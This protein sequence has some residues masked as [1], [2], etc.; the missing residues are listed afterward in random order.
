[1]KTVVVASGKGGTG[2]TTLSVLFAHL[3]ATHH[4]LVVA[5]CDVEASNL[6]L[7]LQV[8]VDGKREFLGTSKPV[9]DAELCTS[10]AVC[11]ESCRF[12]AISL[13]AGDTP[14][15]DEW[16]CEGC[17]VCVSDCP[18]GAIRL[19]PRIAGELMTGISPTG[20]VVFAQL[21]PGEDLSGR[22]VAEVRDQARRLAADNGTDLVLVDG[23]PGV[24]CPTIASL[25][26]A[27]ALV[28]V[29]EPSVS[30]EHDLVRLTA[31]ARRLEVPTCVVLNKADLSARGAERLQP[32][33]TSGAVLRGETR[34]PSGGTVG[35]RRECGPPAAA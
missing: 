34:S 31:L 22:L 24:G 14:I 25:S 10:C 18:M 1:M 6:P 9:L 33:S 28:A 27:D 30:G 26:N 3:F 20:P 11:G 8:E 15:F 21:R 23:P 16:V 7:A 2:K 12:G 17:G 29:A 5:D 4:Q 13:S 19:E 35:D 32:H